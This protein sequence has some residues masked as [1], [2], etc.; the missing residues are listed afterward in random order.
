MVL[1]IYPAHQK[2]SPSSFRCEE[3][4][5]RDAFVEVFFVTKEDIYHIKLKIII[6]P[7][8]VFKSMYV[9]TKEDGQIT[10]DRNPYKAQDGGKCD[11]GHLKNLVY[12]NE[13]CHDDWV[14]VEATLDA[15]K[16]IDCL[17]HFYR[18]CS[19]ATPHSVMLLHNGDLIGQALEKL[20]GRKMP[21]KM[22]NNGSYGDWGIK[23]KNW[24]CTPEALNFANT[25]GL[26]FQVEASHSGGRLGMSGSTYKVK[27]LVKGAEE[28]KTF[29]EGTGTFVINPLN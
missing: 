19:L 6:V 4:N 21:Y 17:G 11:S 29:Y 24:Q 15:M 16:S 13:E 22:S 7:A 25:E 27:C 20:C 18:G 2:D 10:F 14:S 28:G 8:R 3:V 26:H 23:M 9:P 12:S 1:P 5:K